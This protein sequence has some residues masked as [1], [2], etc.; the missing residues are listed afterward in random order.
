VKKNNKWDGNITAETRNFYNII[1][2]ANV[3]GRGVGV[4]AMGATTLLSGV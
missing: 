3:S 2:R 4:T 1:R